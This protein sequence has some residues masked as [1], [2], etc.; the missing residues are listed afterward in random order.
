MAKAYSICD[1]QR[2]Y[3]DAIIAYKNAETTLNFYKTMLKN[4]MAGA[5]YNLAICKEPD[6]TVKAE[7]VG[8]SIA[9]SFNQSAAK[10]KLRELLQDRYNED[11]YYRTSVKD[12]YIKVSIEYREGDANA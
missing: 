2:E 8:E 5:G 3:A 7:L 6:V 4:E 1:L 10:T 11:D 9:R 12:S